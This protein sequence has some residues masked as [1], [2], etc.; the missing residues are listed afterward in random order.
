M[1]VILAAV[2]LPLKLTVAVLLAAAVLAPSAAGSPS[3]DLSTMLADLGRDEKLTACRFTTTQLKSAQQQITGDVD[4]Y[5]KG[6]RPAIK[7]ELKRWADGK[8]KN[9]RGYA[10][11]KIV[12][13]SPTGEPGNES[14]TI[15]NIGKKA[16]NLRNYALRDRDDHVLRLRKTTLKA[17]K[18][19]R[20]VT[21]CRSGSSQGRAQGL[22]LL[23]LQVRR[24]LGRRR[25]S[26][27]AARPRRRADLQEDVRNL[28]DG[29]PA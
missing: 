18:S 12:K 7:R 3:A 1:F 14:I 29:S 13:V 17:G 28:S 4:A 24:G 15:K 10:K 9:K 6:I 23:R 27:R 5:A 8:C 20:V 19:M 25:R 11:L 22:A 2:K 21:G 16:A 26:R